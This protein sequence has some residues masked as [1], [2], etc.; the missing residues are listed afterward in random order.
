MHPLSV[1]NIP[2]VRK[3]EDSTS[4]DG[5]G[6][7]GTPPLKGAVTLCSVHY[8]SKKCQKSLVAAT[9]IYPLGISRNGEYPESRGVRDIPHTKAANSPPEVANSPPEVA[10]APPE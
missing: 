4:C 3:R 8:V 1:R 7:K 2:I 5:G 9:G 10:N 6:G